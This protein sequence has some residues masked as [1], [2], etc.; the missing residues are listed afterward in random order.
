MKSVEKLSEHLQ[1]IKESVKLEFNR[2]G[3]VTE[4]MYE[5]GRLDMIS[6]IESWLTK[7]K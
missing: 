4:K 7:Q 2:A 3:T 5:K 6:E 1:N